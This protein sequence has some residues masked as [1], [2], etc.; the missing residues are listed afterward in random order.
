M[1]V[2][3]NGWRSTGDVNVL[4]DLMWDCT[5]LSRE[6]GRQMATLLRQ[7]QGPFTLTL[8]TTEWEWFFE[9]AVDYGAYL[10]LPLGP[11]LEE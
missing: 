3:I 7:G 4:G 9:R 10:V 2:L 6:Q 1:Q 11:S 8:L 5:S